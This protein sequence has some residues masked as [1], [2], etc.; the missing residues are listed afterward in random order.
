MISAMRIAR[1]WLTMHSSQPNVGVG[2]SNGEEVQ[3]SVCHRGAES[4]TMTVQK[5]VDGEASLRKAG[6]ECSKQNELM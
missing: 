6:G 5:G 4:S 2:A 1:M 3:T